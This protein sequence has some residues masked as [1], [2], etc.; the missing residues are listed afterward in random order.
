MHSMFWVFAYICSGF[1][2]A[3]QIAGIT[4]GTLIPWDVRSHPGKTRL[5]DCSLSH[6]LKS[7]KQNQHRTSRPAK[8]CCQKV[9]PTSVLRSWLHIFS[10]SLIQ[11]WAKIPKVASWVW[12]DDVLLTSGPKAWNFRGFTAS[13]T[14]TKICLMILVKPKSSTIDGR[15]W[16]KAFKSCIFVQ[17]QWCFLRSLDLIRCSSDIFNYAQHDF[18]HPVHLHACIFSVSTLGSLRG[19]LCWVPWQPWTLV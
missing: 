8:N 16:A 2:L 11:L 17:T 19:R 18:A 4:R 9:R 10:I 14:F 3:T 7:R 15:K 6:K 12:Q 5:S 13:I 1:K